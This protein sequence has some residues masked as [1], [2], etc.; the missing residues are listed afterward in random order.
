M[1]ERLAGVVLRELRHAA[2]LLDGDWAALPGW[3]PGAFKAGSREH[4]LG[5]QE[6]GETRDSGRSAPC[7]QQSGI[8]CW[9]CQSHRLAAG[10]VSTEGARRHSCSVRLLATAVQVCVACGTLGVGFVRCLHGS[11]NRDRM[12]GAP[13]EE[14]VNLLPK[15]RGECATRSEGRQRR[16]ARR[17]ACRGCRR[18]WRS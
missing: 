7:A 2:E 18:N 8:K 4:W 6:I 17:S 5:W 15:Q 3:S 11:R 12:S 13:P 16:N 9:R 1:T 14:P 10:L